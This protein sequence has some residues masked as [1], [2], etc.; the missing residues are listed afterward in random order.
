MSRNVV[1]T[2]FPLLHGRQTKEEK[3][4]ILRLWTCADCIQFNGA[5]EATFPC[6]I[7]VW[8]RAWLDCSY[9]SYLPRYTSECADRRWRVLSFIKK[10]ETGARK[11]KRSILLTRVSSWRRTSTYTNEYG[12]VH[13]HAL[14]DCMQLWYMGISCKINVFQWYRH[15]RF[16]KL[17]FMLSSGAVLMQYLYDRVRLCDCYVLNCGG[18]VSSCNG[19]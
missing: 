14:T 12:R 6:L 18:G 2:N 17:T 7:Y 8:V 5:E 4:R 9:I 13:M 3:K 15:Y 1:K 10:E 11:F 16:K 19:L